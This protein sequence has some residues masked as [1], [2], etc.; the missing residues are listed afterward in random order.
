LQQEWIDLDDPTRLGNQEAFVVPAN[1][2]GLPD[3][4][5][6]AALLSPYGSTRGADAEGVATPHVA[7][8]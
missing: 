2:D 6:A 1:V 4:L 8:A 7:N 3:R 5:P